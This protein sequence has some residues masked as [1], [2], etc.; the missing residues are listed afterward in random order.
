MKTIDLH[1]HSNYSDGTCTPEELVELAVKKGLAAFALTDHDA[2]RGVN[3]IL[4]YQ[5]KTSAPVEII[6]GIEISSE[7]H[8]KEIHIV[9]LYVNQ[10]NQNLVETTSH[11]VN[12]RAKRNQ[13]MVENFQNAGIPMTMEDLQ[14][15][16]PGTVITRAHFTRFLIQHGV[17]KNAKEAFSQYL[18]E[19]SPFY[20]SRKLISAT[21]AISLILEAGG[22]PILAHPIHYHMEEQVLRSMIKTFKEHGL[23]G[24]EVKYSNHTKK[25]EIFVR[26]LAKEFDLLSSGGSDFHGTN[27]PDIDLGSGRGNLSIPY[28]YLEGIKKY[29]AKNLAQ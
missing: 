12:L 21:D 8:K 24:I 25:D 20:V 5:K 3:P 19:D 13:K 14:E 17:V 26:H 23:V 15:G 9:G 4:A 1:V 29:H 22:V 18:G 28:E 6:P 11:F 10:D 27:K 7:Y 16:N 2:T